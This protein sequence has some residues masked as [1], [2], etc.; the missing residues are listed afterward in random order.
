MKKN[1]IIALLTL[2]FTTSS[3]CQ[4]SAISADPSFRYVSNPGFVNI[5]E[6]NGASGLRDTLATNAGYYFGITNVFGYQIDKNFFGGIGVGFY[7][8]DVGNLIPFYLEYKYSYYLKRFTPYLYGD[9]GI[10]IHP[11]ELS[12]ES[13]IFINP[14]IGISRVISSNLEINLSAGY[15][16]QSRSNLTRVTFVNFKM[17]VIFRKNS[18]RMFRKSTKLF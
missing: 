2:S 16:I 10:L 9:G 7:Y 8:Y 1:L 5:T 14:G 18:F 12:E 3:Y 13:K 11:T 6:L 17:G 4:Y 15:M